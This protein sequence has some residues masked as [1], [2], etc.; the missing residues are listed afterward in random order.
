MITSS[1]SILRPNLQPPLQY[2]CLQWGQ[3]QILDPFR[4]QR[5]FHL[6][7][8]PFLADGDHG[9]RMFSL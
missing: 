5:T 6:C 7:K 4:L 1:V 2:I 3:Q 8:I 9:K